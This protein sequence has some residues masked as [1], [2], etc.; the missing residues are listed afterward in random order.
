VLIAVFAAVLFG[1]VP[2]LRMAGGNLQESLKDSGPGSGQG[3]RHER[4]RSALV[5]SE[6]ALA[7]MLLVGAGLLLRSFMKVLDVDLGF[8]PERA[9]AIKV[10]YDDSAPPED[11]QSIAKRT[12][13]L[14]GILSRVGALPGVEAA[15]MVDYLPM[16][17]NRAWGTPTPQG[18]EAPGVKFPGGRWFTWSR[19]GICAPWARGCGARLHLGRR[20]E[21]RKCGD[22]QRIVRE[23]FWPATRMAQRRRV[24]KVLVTGR[25]GTA[26]GG[27]G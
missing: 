14:S 12:L 7:C 2:G 22:D 16:G 4:V 27:R 5:V 11:L 18:S 21:E 23:A 10:D 26:H 9:A 13:D 19:R 20:A 3:R 15:G 8:Q 25:T 1:L 24:G 6:I 17:Q